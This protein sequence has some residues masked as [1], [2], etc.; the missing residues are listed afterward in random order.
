[1]ANTIRTDYVHLTNTPEQKQAQEYVGSVSH[2]NIQS[3][4]TVF[5]KALYTIQVC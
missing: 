3:F 5:R 2:V 4:C 1:M